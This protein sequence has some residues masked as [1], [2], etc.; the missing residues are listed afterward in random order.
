MRTILL[1]LLLSLCATPVAAEITIGEATPVTTHQ[2]DQG[3]RLHATVGYPAAAALGFGWKSRGGTEVLVQ[4]G[5]FAMYVMLLGTLE[6]AA[7]HDWFRRPW[8]ALHA[9]L[10]A[11]FVNTHIFVIDCYEGESCEDFAQNLWLASPRVGIRLRLDRQ[12]RHGMIPYLDLN[13][14]PQV[15]LCRGS[16]PRGDLLVNAAVNIRGVIDF[17]RRTN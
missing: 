3:F 15:G 5:G 6:A 16:C 9:G 1:S 11:S 17:Q 10:A 4:A 14:G 12:K 7:S 13:A 2:Q 8:G